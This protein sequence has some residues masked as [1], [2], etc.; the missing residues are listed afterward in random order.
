MRR[1]NARL[2]V[3]M[4]AQVT[5]SQNQLKLRQQ[6]LSDSA[7]E[8]TNQVR[9]TPPGR[10]ECQSLHGP[11]EE[12]WAEREQQQQQQQQQQAQQAQQEQQAQQ[13]QQAQQ[14]LQEQQEQQ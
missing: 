8:K 6:R 10:V 4:M 11:N 1:V 12:V 3:A 5:Q 9:K 7:A 2:C 14:E 13:A